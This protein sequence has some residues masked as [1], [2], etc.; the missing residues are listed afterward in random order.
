[1]DDENISFCAGVVGEKYLWCINNCDGGLYRINKQ[2]FQVELLA[3]IA[4]CREDCWPYVKATIYKNK[5]YFFPLFSNEKIIVYDNS[6]NEMKK[7]SLMKPESNICYSVAIDKEN[8]LFFP[9]NSTD[10]IVYFNMSSGQLR[11]TSKVKLNFHNNTVFANGK[12]WIPIYNSNKLVEFDAETGVFKIHYVGQYNLMAIA[13]DGNLFWLSILN[14]NKVISWSQKTGEIKVYE[15][16]ESIGEVET[17]YIPIVC[18]SN[19]VLL[20]SRCEM[21]INIVDQESGEIKKAL[22]MPQDFC[23]LPNR[24]GYFYAEY[25]LV[26]DEIWVFPVWGNR[27]L[28]I[29]TL[30]MEIRGHVLLIP[31]LKLLYKKYFVNRSAIYT[32]EKFDLVEYNKLLKFCDS[33]SE[34]NRSTNKMD[35]GNTIYEYVRDSIKI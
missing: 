14:E 15:K 6:T 25:Q 22:E 8:V 3:P 17:Y 19:R 11:Y 27:L 10:K 16:K 24:W 7:I 29:N 34:Y 30:T 35:C 9:R 20:L 18:T 33:P 21:D 4:D 13:F 26:G 31:S 23:L 32:E 12:F 28:I 5:I 2:S 1:M